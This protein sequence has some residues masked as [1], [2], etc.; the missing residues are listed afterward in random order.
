MD[1][2]GTGRIGRTRGPSASKPSAAPAG[3]SFTV[4]TSAEAPRAAGVIS[5]GP[6]TALES[7][8][9]L[10][11]VGDAAT[12][13][14]KGLARGNRLLD[15]LDEVRDGLLSGTIPQATLQRLAASVSNREDV[16][17]DPALQGVLDEIELRAH[18]E[19][20]KLEQAQRA[21]A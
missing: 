9:A 19:L 17:A 2:N 21:A 4:S 8:L 1:I 20:A 6:L 13:R 3:E 15:M 12:G 7:I 14:S 16:F 18:V 10:Q 5:S 11:G